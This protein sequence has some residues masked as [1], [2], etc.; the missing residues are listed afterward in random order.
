MGGLQCSRLRTFTRKQP[1]SFTYTATFLH[2][3]RLDKLL[4]GQLYIFVFLLIAIP[5]IGVIKGSAADRDNIL[6]KL[7]AHR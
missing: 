3:H 4:F 2:N 5:L 6:L 7:R 1:V